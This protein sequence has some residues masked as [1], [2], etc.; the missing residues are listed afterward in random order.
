PEYCAIISD[1]PT[2]AAKPHLVDIQEGNFD[3]GVLQRAVAS[4]KLCGIDEVYASSEILDAVEKQ[5]VPEPGQVIIDLRDE[6]CYERE[7]LSLV[8]NSTLNIPFYKLNRAFAE[9]DANQQYLLYCD[10]GVMSRLHAAHLCAEG[11][12][13]VKV[14]QPAQ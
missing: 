1:K 11:Y 6:E 7:P 12:A 14:Y 9:L 8:G 10:R 3:F 5:S 13:N 2:T 4:R